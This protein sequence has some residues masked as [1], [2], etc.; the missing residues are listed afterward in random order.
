MT[1]T[2]TPQNY[3]PVTVTGPNGQ[4]WPFGFRRGLQWPWASGFPFRDS[5]T[6]AGWCST[7]GCEAAGGAWWRLK[8]AS[9]TSRVSPC[10]LVASPPGGAPRGWGALPAA[11]LGIAPAVVCLFPAVSQGACGLTRAPSVQESLQTPHFCQDEALRPVRRG[12]PRL[13]GRACPSDAP[14]HREMKG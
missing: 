5:R 12:T 13:H 11:H 8:V 7:C 3:S 2:W 10:V 9:R 14:P 1:S 4:V 6:E